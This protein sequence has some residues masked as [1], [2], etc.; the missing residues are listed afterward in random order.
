MWLA[1]RQRRTSEVWDPDEPDP[2]H[3]MSGVELPRYPSVTNKRPKK[4]KFCLK[5]NANTR[6]LQHAA[7]QNWLSTAS[8]LLEL[9]DASPTAL[10]PNTHHSALSI[11]WSSRHYALFYILLTHP[12]TLPLPLTPLH[13][14]AIRPVHVFDGNVNA[15][16]E[17]G[18]TPLHYAAGWGNVALCRL[19]VSMGA[20][21]HTRDAG[22]VSVGMVA[23][24]VGSVG[25]IRYLKELGAW[26]PEWVTAAIVRGELEVLKVVVEGVEIAVSSV[27]VAAQSGRLDI[28]K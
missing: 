21:I 10:D 2:G 27:H 23:V 18:A 28:L 5:M 20:C 25:V 14:L 8:T 24:A 13:L 16:D 19:L 11:A 17:C 15:D 9:G 1:V 26:D 7:R 6:T 12:Q 4:F 3:N 22:G